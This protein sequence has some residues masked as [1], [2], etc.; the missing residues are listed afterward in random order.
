M[1]VGQGS[2]QIIQTDSQRYF[3]IDAGP[4]IKIGQRMMEFI[5]NRSGG[6][7]TIEAVLISHAHADHMAGLLEILQLTYHF[8]RRSPGEWPVGWPRIRRVAIAD[9]NWRKVLE[10][11]ETAP[12]AHLVKRAWVLLASIN[13][14]LSKLPSAVERG[15]ESI[16]ID[17]HSLVLEKHL[18]PIQDLYPLW[19]SDMAGKPAA[20]EAVSKTPMP[21]TPIPRL[22]L[23]YPD[24]EDYDELMTEDPNFDRNRISAV[25]KLEYAG[26]STLFP[27]DAP[28]EVWDKLLQR[29][30]SLVQ[31]IHVT[32]VPH[33]GGRIFDEDY[34]AERLKRLNTLYMSIVNSDRAVGI[35]SVGTLKGQLPRQ[36]YGHP[37]QEVIQSLRACRADVMCTQ[38]TENCLDSRGGERVVE[39]L[40]GV[41]LQTNSLRESSL[42]GAGST[43]VDS[44]ASGGRDYPRNVSCASSVTITIAPDGQWS[45][46]RLA[47]HRRLVDG[48]SANVPGTLPLCRM[49]TEEFE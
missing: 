5:S 22:L 30:K 23:L 18:N 15:F 11:P 46:H 16:R 10:M 6:L 44:V 7:A 8:C 29:H 28:I 14:E 20:T 48:L 21:P 42:P 26:I 17:F 27:G 2:C 12:E 45:V 31:G 19:S 34:N 32:V 36:G 39:L 49:G 24:I 3:L 37:H 40:E 35:V 1:D 25:I 47:E 41:R 13:R 4:S 9:P 33:H 43:F 38:F